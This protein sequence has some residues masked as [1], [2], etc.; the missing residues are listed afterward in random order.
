MPRASPSARLL[1]GEG[2]EEGHFQAGRGIDV[3]AW[4]YIPFPV[5]AFL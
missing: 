4:V 2:Q 5:E 1:C 3:V